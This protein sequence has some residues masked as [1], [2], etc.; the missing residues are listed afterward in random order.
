MKLPTV[1]VFHVRGPR[2]GVGYGIGLIAALAA[3]VAAGAVYARDGAVAGWEISIL[4]FFNGFPDWLT[5]PMWV[6]QQPGVL[7]FPFAAGAVIVALSRRWHYALPFL[8]LPVYKLSLE[9]E[10]VKT[11]VD[12]S[13]P[14]TS[15]GPEIQARGQ[16]LLDEPSFPSGHATTAVAC[17]ILI[18][19]FLPPRWRPVPVVWGL[20]VA[21]GRL[22]YGEHNTLDVICGAAL[23]T[24]FAIAAWLLFINRWVGDGPPADAPAEEATRAASTAGSFRSWNGRR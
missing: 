12:R 17:G 10:L 19:F 22:Y 2:L 21:V 4:K 9:K 5:A 23:G 1:N 11:R 24:A 7:F 13:R 8:L 18:A 6:V 15:V 3:I 16:S 20:L 14:Y